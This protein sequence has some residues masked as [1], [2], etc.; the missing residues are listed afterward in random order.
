MCRG[1]APQSHPASNGM[2]LTFY[3]A[4][5]QVTG[6]NFLLES[7]GQKIL[8]D[9]GLNQGDSFVEKMN[10]E[11]FPYNPKE[12]LAALVTHPHVDHV[13]R[14]PKLYKDGFRGN[15]YSTP[16]CRDAAELLLTD[17]EHILIQEA[18]KLQQPVLYGVREIEELMTLW[19]GVEYHKPFQVGPFKVTL[20]NAGHVLGSSFILVEAEGKRIIFSGD[21]G[22]SPAPL[23]GRREELPENI[24]YC[25]VE[26]TY[27]N[28]IHP[29]REERTAIL[30]KMIE[31]TVKKKGVLMIPAFALERTQ[32]LLFELDGLVEHGRIP[33]VPIFIDSP[34]AIKLT[35]VYKKYPKYLDG[36]TQKLMRT[37]DGI[38]S[39]PG[40]KMTLTVDES[41]RINDVPAPKVI[42][43][44]AGMSN[45]GR[46]L[47]HERRYLSDSKNAILIVGYQAAGSL[48]RKLLDGDKTVRVLGDEVVVRCRIVQA[49]A[50]SAHADQPQLLE[51]LAPLKG[52]AKKVFVIHAEPDG[53]KELAQK[54]RDELSVPGEVPTP[55][56]VVE[57]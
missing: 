8:I 18:E 55:G 17:S 32:E 14:L 26:G 39:F 37:G 5:Q 44:G 38:F 52:H 11:P 40:L 53:A 23:I 51:W 30:E 48:G 19:R 12:I 34:L 1:Y 9:C 6:S 54:M 21:L 33:K 10:F 41:K 3:G 22:N 28:R 36:E 16:P 2:K 57:L 35:E 56:E 25:L 46:I 49:T 13:G 7:S 20:Y 15:V 29:P 47:H 24:D 43:A 27:G 42:I 31:E 50:Y 45:A 4:T